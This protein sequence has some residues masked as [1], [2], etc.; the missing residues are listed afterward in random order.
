MNRLTSKE[1]SKMMEAGNQLAE[2]TNPVMPSAVRDEARKKLKDCVK[3]MLRLI[4]SLRIW[5]LLLKK[6]LIQL[7]NKE[8]RS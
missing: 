3:L 4:N 8:R 5:M 2:L 1:V 6:V 7:Q